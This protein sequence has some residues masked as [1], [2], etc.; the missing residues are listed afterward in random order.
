MG[1]NIMTRMV[2]GEL[3]FSS[4]IF[5]SKKGIDFFLRENILHS[6]LKTR[7]ENKKGSTYYA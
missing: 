6:K 1:V 3:V 4:R 7:I 2:E 5:L